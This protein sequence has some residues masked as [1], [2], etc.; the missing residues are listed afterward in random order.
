[1][2]KLLLLAVQIFSYAIYL[3]LTSCA[4]TNDYSGSPH[5]FDSDYSNRMPAQTDTGGKKM[6][7]IDPN[8]HAWGAYDANGQLVRAGIATSGSA[9]CPPDAADESDCRTGSGTFHITAMQGAECYSKTYPKPHGGGLMPF[10]MYFNKGQALHGSPDNIV[11]DANISH[12]CVRMRIPDAEWM[13]HNFANVG[14]K[15]VVLP[16]NE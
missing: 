2:R 15:V 1:M 8:A 13:Q 12:G 9:V 14:T 16:Y 6:V 4:S 7:L 3:S 10:C 5:H 11:V